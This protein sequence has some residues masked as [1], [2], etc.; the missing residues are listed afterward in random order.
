MH[1]LVHGMKYQSIGEDS[2]TSGKLIRPAPT[3]PTSVLSSS[4]P[5][6]PKLADAFTARIY[7][8][9][10]RR[11]D[12][13]SEQI[14]LCILFSSRFILS[15]SCSLALTSSNAFSV[16]S[17]AHTITPYNSAI[18]LASDS[19]TFWLFETFRRNTL[20]PFSSSREHQCRQQKIQPQHHQ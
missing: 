3:R 14:K 11:F 18:F 19:A 6:S 17:S 8:S 2:L 10:I 15:R 7:L 12:S 20:H 9:S 5:G 4:H 1:Y 13:S 16:F